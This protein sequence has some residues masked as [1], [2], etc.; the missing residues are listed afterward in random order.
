MPAEFATF[1]DPSFTEVPGYLKNVPQLF[2][3]RVEKSADDIAMREKKLGIWRSITWADYG[4][5][6]KHTGLALWALGVRAGDVTCVLADNRPEWLYADMGTMGIGAVSSGVYTTDSAHQIAY[7]LNDCGA[8]VLFVENDEQ[9]DKA[10]EVRDRVPSL[11]K[12]V[13]MDMDGLR[14]FS[15]PMVISFSALLMLGIETEAAQPDLWT[16]TIHR[17]A[18]EDT[19][20]LVYT[21]GTTGPPKGAMLSHKNIL[22]QVYATRPILPRVTGDQQLSFLPLCHIAERGFSVHYPLIAASTINFVESPETVPENIREVQP[23][24]FLAVPRVWE[25][26]YS[27]INIAL[28]D[29]TGWQRRAYNAALGLGMKK[30]GFELDAKPVP[31]WLKAAFWVADHLVLRNVKRMIGIDRCRYL[32]TGAAPISPDLIRWYLALGKPMLEVYG[33]TETT[34]VCTAMRP[35]QIKLKTIGQAT[36]HVA[37]KLS[38]QNEILVRGDCVFSGYFNKPDKTAETIVDGWLHTGDVGEMDGEGFFRITDRMKDIIITAGGKNIT[39]SEIENELKFSPYISD[40]VVIGDRRKFLSCLIMIDHENVVKFAQDNDVP[41]TNFT[42]LCRTKEVV[43]LIDGEV[44][45]VNAKFARVEQIKQ[46]RL[47]D[48]Q[49]TAEDDELTPTM[50]LKRKFVEKKYAE[51]IDTMY[52]GAA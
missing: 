25:K 51:L 43:D 5:H 19:A 16:Q 39:P 49:L 28:R 7:I 48:Q 36:P 4:R 23:T 20:I 24:L 50:K 52:Q 27:A 17:P 14:E 30:S 41:F 46:F 21:S 1:E 13:V 22:F 10:L 15:D 35:E 47:I 31:A 18:P 2:W 8:K 34:G 29:A 33:Q 9:L 11:I 38:P 45:Q 37:V 3:A 6:A 12:I 40:A 32:V 44:N 26:F 42:S